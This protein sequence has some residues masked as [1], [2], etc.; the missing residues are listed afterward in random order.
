MTSEFTHGYAVVISIDSN[1]IARLALPSVLKDAEALYEVLVH[2]ERCAY[3][4]EHVKLLKGEESTQRNIFDA[5]YWLQEKV[6]ADPEA[7]AV[8][9]Y[10][11]HGMVDKETEQYYLVPYDIQGL[12]RIR[13]DAIRAETLTAEISAIPAKR[14]LVVLDCCHAAGMDVKD[15]D[16]DLSNGP[17]VAAKAFPLDLPETKAIPEYEAGSKDVADLAEGE[18]RAILNSSKGEQKSYVRRDG[19]MSL[20]TYHLIEALTGHA[21]HPDDAT[22]VYVTDVMSWVTHEV[23]KSAAREGVVQTPVMRT[24][25]VFP[26]AQLLGGKGVATAKGEIP[27]DPLQ[28][29]PPTSQGDQVGRD[30]I[31]TG[32]IT[33][34]QGV[35]IGSGASATV[36][37]GDTI[38][39]SGNFSGSNVNVKSTLTNVTQTIGTLP[40][41]SQADKQTLEQL[42]Q[43]L[44]ALLQQAPPTQAATASEVAEATEIL[45]NTAAAETPNKTMI[46]M[47]GEGLKQAAQRLKDDLPQIVDITAHIVTIVTAVAGQAK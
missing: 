42:V 26:V 16:L 37:T 23:K 39:I 2:P 28:P 40:H 36:H 29:L 17:N 20:F 18:G 44:H 46:K 31:T 25:G 30:K 9:Y 15:I 43:Q 5:L 33:A 24:T 21:P 32:D 1:Q 6:Q 7:T 4:P 45:I 38:N 13:A 12:N 8:I 14:M 41:T 35:A 3:K 47:L 11:G 10:T 19:A 34:S 22:V 27:P